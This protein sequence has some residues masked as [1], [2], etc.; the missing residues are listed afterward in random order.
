VA[1]Q[2]Q[3]LDALSLIRRKRGGEAADNPLPAEQEGAPL[4][5]KPRE[6]VQRTAVHVRIPEQIARGLRLMS[7]L[8]NRQAQDLV[9][10]AIEKMLDGWSGN[11]R[12]AVPKR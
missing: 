2:P 5:M 3:P 12:D 10:E 11:W 9:A 6:V 7:V 4:R 1:D 8:E